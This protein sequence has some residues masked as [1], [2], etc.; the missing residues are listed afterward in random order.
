M[1]ILKYFAVAYLLNFFWEAWHA[2][3]LYWGYLG[4]SF[5]DYSIPEYLGLIGKVSF[6]DAGILTAVFL[7]GFL[8]WPSETSLA[9]PAKR[10]KGG[11]EWNWL[12]TTLR[13]SDFLRLAYFLVATISIAIW[14]E[15]KGVYILG[16]WSYLPTMPTIFGLGLSPLLQL[17]TTGFLSFWILKKTP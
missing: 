9:S 13:K 17:S 7:V 5:I 4:K 1:F 10:A 15:I 8:V 6:V 2:Y 3:Y 11:K 14:I 16:E 12:N